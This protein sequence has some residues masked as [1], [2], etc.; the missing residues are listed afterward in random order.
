MWFG[1]RRPIPDAQP[2]PRAPET[3]IG[4]LWAMSGDWGR[5]C[6]F[7]FIVFGIVLTCCLGISVIVLAVKGIH[8][9]TRYVVPA[10][11]FGGGSLLTL[12]TVMIKRL[13]FVRN[14]QGGAAGDGKRSTKQ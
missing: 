9:P 6:R 14:R 1:R 2:I 11:V 5:A 8:T 4:L 13:L 7:V 10:G 12:I 3:F